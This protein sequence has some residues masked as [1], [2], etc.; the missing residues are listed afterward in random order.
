[1]KWNETDKGKNNWRVLQN[2]CFLGLLGNVKR[3][4]EKRI[5]LFSLVHHL[6]VL[7]T[8][9]WHTILIML[10][11]YIVIYVMFLNMYFVVCMLD[12]V[13][14]G[15][16]V[17]LHKTSY[18]TVIFMPSHTSDISI[19]SWNIFSVECLCLCWQFKKYAILITE[20]FSTKLKLSAV[21][22]LQLWVLSFH[23]VTQLFSSLVPNGYVWQVV[24]KCLS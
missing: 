21:F 3:L 22:V 12:S 9:T 7:F 8:T 14:C 4:I 6:L 24:W 17:P 23:S 15:H 10:G 19:C 2:C 18:P 20:L 11:I 16:L 1:M 5:Y 13:I